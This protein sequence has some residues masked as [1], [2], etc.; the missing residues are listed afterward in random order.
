MIKRDNARAGVKDN[1]S[2]F[3]LR[4]P[5]SASYVI[6]LVTGRLTVV[7]S[8]KEDVMSITDHLDTQL[9]ATNM[10]ELGMRRG[11]V[12]IPLA[13]KLFLGVEATSLD[14][15]YIPTELDALRKLEDYLMLPRQRMKSIWSSNL[16]RKLKSCVMVPA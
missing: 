2:G 5:R 13:L 12:K 16:E 14:L 7:L 10:A 3:P 6:A 15:R 4:V 1:L 9:R 11:S 8:Q